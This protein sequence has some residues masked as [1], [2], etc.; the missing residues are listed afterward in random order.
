MVKVISTMPPPHMVR[1]V[2]CKNCG[3]TL[4]YMPRDIKSYTSTDYGGGTDVHDY[5][6]CPTC[7]NKVSVRK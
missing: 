5:I 3:S 6:L 4:E 1:Q 2:V 7:S